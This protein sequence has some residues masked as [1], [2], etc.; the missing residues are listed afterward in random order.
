MKDCTEP[1]RPDESKNGSKPTEDRCK[2]VHK[3][4]QYMNGQ[5]HKELRPPQNYWTDWQ[6]DG[7][8]DRT[9]RSDD[10]RMDGRGD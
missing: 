1:S 7:V 5:Q 4:G 8:A 3:D 6:K 9:H 10:R 2:E